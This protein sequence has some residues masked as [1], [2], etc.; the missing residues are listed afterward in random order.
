MKIVGKMTGT[1]NANSSHDKN[2]V[3]TPT[4]SKGKMTSVKS[5]SVP[6]G[7]KSTTFAAKR[8]VALKGLWGGNKIAGGK[9]A[10]NDAAVGK[11][12]IQH[13]TS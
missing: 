6:L 9:G 8:T 10:G 11:K 4:V 5:S 2:N 12:T 1:V 7:K 13:M 3:A